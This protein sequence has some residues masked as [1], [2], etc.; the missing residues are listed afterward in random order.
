M[1][2]GNTR[3]HSLAET[4][5]RRVNLRSPVEEQGDSLKP[6]KFFNHFL[7]IKTYNPPNLEIFNTN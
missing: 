1:T 6:C 2:P 4:N 5:P 3:V 7:K